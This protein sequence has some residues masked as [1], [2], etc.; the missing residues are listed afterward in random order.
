MF[1]PPDCLDLVSRDGFYCYYNLKGTSYVMIYDEYYGKKRI[2]L[3]QSDGNF[4]T[5]NKMDLTEVPPEQVFEEASE[6]DKESLIFHMD[7]FV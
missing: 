2:W 6:T 4:E 3:I 5:G 1:N 7:L